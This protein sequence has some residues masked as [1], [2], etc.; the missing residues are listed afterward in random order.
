MTWTMRVAFLTIRFV[1]V[2]R[3]VDLGRMFDDSK[4]L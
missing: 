2:T 3:H 4:T 1:G